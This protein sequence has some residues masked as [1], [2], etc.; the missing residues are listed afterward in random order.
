MTAWAW[1]APLAGVGLLGSVL[2]TGR[3]RLP[4]GVLHLVIFAAFVP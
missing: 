2:A 1:L 4:H 3:T